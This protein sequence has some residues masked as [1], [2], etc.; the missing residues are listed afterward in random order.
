MRVHRDRVVTITPT[1][2][3]VIVST[4]APPEKSLSLGAS[5]RAYRTIERECAIERTLVPDAARGLAPMSEAP[6]SILL[7]GISQEI[8]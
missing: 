2:T 8:R 7:P 6:K 1:G 5:G 3:N 4:D